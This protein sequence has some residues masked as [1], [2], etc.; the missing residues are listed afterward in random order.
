MPPCLQ[1]PRAPRS[2]NLKKGRAM[3]SSP[4]TT[5]QPQANQTDDIDTKTTHQP[6]LMSR[7]QVEAEYG[8]SRRWLEQAALTGNGPSFI[9]I[10]RRTVRY[11]RDDLER[12]LGERQ[13]KSTADP[14]TANDPP[15]SALTNACSGC[16]ATG[17][18]TCPAEVAMA[19]KEPSN[20]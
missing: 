12:W 8:I 19:Q 14:G 9:K 16:S 15:R 18:R 13:V 3:S 6:L 10:A 1:K 5:S 7:A 4:T 17:P 11:R 2:G 20:D